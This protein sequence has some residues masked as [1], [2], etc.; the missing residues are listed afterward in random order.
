MDRGKTSLE[1]GG[2]TR[3]R[4]E[5]REA[6]EGEETD[7]GIRRGVQRRHSCMAQRG[8]GHTKE[9]EKTTE[10]KS[11]TLWGAVA[12]ILRDNIGGGANASSHAP[13]PTG[14]VPHARK[15]KKEK[16]THHLQCTRATSW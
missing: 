1:E 5:Q 6:W 4:R 13:R 10:H 7:R 15:T 3:E 16:G 2:P 9:L 12:S 11:A 8:W 14:G